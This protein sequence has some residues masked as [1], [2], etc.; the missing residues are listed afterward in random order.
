MCC[1]VL[2]EWDWSLKKRVRRAKGTRELVK[3]GRNG[4]IKENEST[5]RIRM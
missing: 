2:K 3:E 1:V 4:V 5:G